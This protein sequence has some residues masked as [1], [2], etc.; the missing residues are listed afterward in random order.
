MAAEGP[1]N[2]RFPVIL[3][4]DEDGVYIATCPTFRGCRSF[5]HTIDEAMANVREA[6]QLCL[7][8]EPG[9]P[10]NRFVGVRDVEIQQGA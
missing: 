3:E 7:D 1:H 4:Q 8:D 2:R 9:Q 5:G 6:I 10:V